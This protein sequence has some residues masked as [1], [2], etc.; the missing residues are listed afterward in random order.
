MSGMTGEIGV[1]VGG[2][3]THSQTHH[4][5]VIDDL[6]RELGDRE[7]PATAVVYAALALWLRSVGELA[8]VGVE[9]TS[10]YSAG[11]AR[12][13]YQVGVS[14]VE[15]NRPDRRARRAHGKSDPIDAYAAPRAAL[16]ATRTTVPKTGDGIVE[17]IRA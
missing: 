2:V 1:V 7:F 5:A 17:A 4:V 15:V 11:L 14:V 3:D 12:Y 10:S 8:R 6:G 13:L 16:S 9:D